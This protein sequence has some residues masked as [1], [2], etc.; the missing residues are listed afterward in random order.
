MSNMRI[1]SLDLS[2]WRA[3]AKLS[4]ASEVGSPSGM[5]EPTRTTAFGFSSIF[6]SFM[7]FSSTWAVSVMVKVPWGT[8]MLLTELDST[9]STR[10]S[11]SSFH[12]NPPNVSSFPYFSH[13]NQR[14]KLHGFTSFDFQQPFLY[15]YCIL[16]FDIHLQFLFEINVVILRISMFSNIDNLQSCTCS[17][18][19]D[20][21][22]VTITNQLF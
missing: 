15:P 1:A 12:S 7:A 9:A 2:H 22:L 19:R 4:R 3:T 5:R 17:G 11:L 16:H 8:R 14:K 13:H 20:G 18:R 21:L 10:A 6:S